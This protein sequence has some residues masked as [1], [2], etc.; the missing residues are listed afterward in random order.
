MSSAPNRLTSTSTAAAESARA[1]AL[2]DEKAELTAEQ[3]EAEYDIFTVTE[4]AR[5]LKEEVCIV[6]IERVSLAAEC[7]QTHL[8]LPYS[9]SSFTLFSS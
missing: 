5:I 9:P 6:F 1:L 7:T 2:R 8:T 3:E 4:T